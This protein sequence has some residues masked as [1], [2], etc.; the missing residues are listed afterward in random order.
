[1]LWGQVFGVV[2]VEERWCVVEVVV[3]LQLPKVRSLRLGNEY[4]QQ[5][6]VGHL[7]GVPNPLCGGKPLQVEQQPVPLQV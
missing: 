7:L 3:V 6:V 2:F 1:M 5:Q 4:P